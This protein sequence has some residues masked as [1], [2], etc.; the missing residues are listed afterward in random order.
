MKK[1]K[2]KQ[3][4]KKMRMMKK[5]KDERE[6]QTESIGNEVWQ[7]FKSASKHGFIIKHI[8]AFKVL[9]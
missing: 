6:E 7:N 4:V 2:K 9:I 5:K 8:D 1:L 3:K